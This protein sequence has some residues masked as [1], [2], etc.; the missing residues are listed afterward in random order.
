MVGRK[1][2]LQ[3]LSDICEL[4]NSSLVAVY[5]RRRIGKTYLINYMFQE[6]RRDCLFFDFT[7][8]SDVRRE[9]QLINFV[10]QVYEWFRVRP[11]QKVDDWHGA[12]RFLKYTIDDEV[13]KRNHKE[14]VIIFLDEVPWIDPNNRDDFLSA[15][16]YFWNT[17]CEKRKNI[18]VILCGSNAS[19]I[20]NRILEESTGPLY[21]RLTH[22]L[23]MYPFDF[24]ETKEYLTEIKGFDI[25]SKSFMEIYMIFGGVAK[26]LSY[27]D[28]KLFISDNIDRIF[29]DIEGFMYDE[30]HAVFRSLFMDKAD[31]HKS[32]IDA[33]CSRP[34]GETINELS[35]SLNITLGAKLADAIA[36]L[37]SC[38][39]I[40]GIG[41][42]GN[43]KKGI[44]YIVSDMYLLFHHKWIKEL[45]KNDI[46]NLPNGYWS[47]IVGT[48]PYA[49]WSG[50]AFETVVITNVHSYLKA[51]GAG[52]LFSGVYYWEYRAKE[53]DERGTQIDMVVEYGNGI[54][55]IVECKY[56]NREYEI[57][58]DYAEVMRNKMVM[59]R[60]Y[61]LKRT[62]KGELKMVFLTTYGL[63]KNSAS[64]SLNIAGELTL[65]DLLG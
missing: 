48:Q 34:R 11:N 9:V 57:T 22:K 41:K 37:E 10:D 30:Y 19:W 55:D 52:G 31:Y 58:K 47:S 14:K 42:F 21:K 36:E 5:G 65:D 40:Q 18:V 60:K 29:F 39:F 43:K 54:Y 63:K 1:K 16:G 35:K 6:Y 53:E 7:G 45:S 25:D 26:Y 27:L 51:R 50:N 24:V 62:Q 59:F 17:Y 64:N 56:Y 32:I 13:E 8:A 61:G 4:D 33:L 23:P 38:G 3:I 28:S 15:L 49:T 44:K 12:F 2:E 46:F 20:K